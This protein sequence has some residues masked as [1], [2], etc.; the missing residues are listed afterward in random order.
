MINN[1]LGMELLKLKGTTPEGVIIENHTSSTHCFSLQIISTFF[2]LFLEQDQILLSHSI[3][4]S[5]HGILI[6]FL[7]P[8]ICK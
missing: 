1:H 7:R 2:F 5:K 3:M 8:F 6:A 4:F